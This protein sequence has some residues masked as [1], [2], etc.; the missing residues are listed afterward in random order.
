V[1]EE[2]AIGFAAEHQRRLKTRRLI[3]ALSRHIYFSSRTLLGG[4][5]TA[6][7]GSLATIPLTL[8]SRLTAHWGRGSGRSSSPLLFGN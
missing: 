4:A 8:F 1:V 6:L 5:L 3:G 7:V 2:I